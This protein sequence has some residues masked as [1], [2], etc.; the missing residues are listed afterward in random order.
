MENGNIN[1]LGEPGT[2]NGKGVGNLP[3]ENADAS[4]TATENTYP[5]KTGIQST[6]G[7]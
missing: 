1:D 3:G 6:V 7:H 5:K 4:D 2:K